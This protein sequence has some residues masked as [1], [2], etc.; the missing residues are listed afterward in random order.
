MYVTTLWQ[1]CLENLY[2]IESKLKKKRTGSLQSLFVIHTFNQN[3]YSSLSIFIQRIYK[4]ML[5]C[6]F[7]KP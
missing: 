4:I 5:I 7:L 3:I 1:K 2:L 6:D